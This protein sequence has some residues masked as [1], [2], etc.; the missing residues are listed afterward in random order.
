MAP[1]GKRVHTVSIHLDPAQYL[2]GWRPEARSLFVP[3]LSES[4]V[5][6]EAAVR[7]AI[8]GQTIR[9]TVYGKVAL[10]RRVGRPSLPPGAE[11]TLDRGSLPAAE[12]LAMASR[13]EKITYR[14]RSPRW[15]VEQ[16]LLVAWG[17]GWVKVQT[18]NVA[19]GGCA[20]RW[21]PPLP[22]VGEVLALRMPGSMFPPTARA[23]VC[24]TQAEGPLGRAIGLRVVVEGRGGRA[25]LE[26]VE[27][28]SQEG[29]PSA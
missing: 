4:R 6:D 21:A 18:I 24:W 7:V 8:V 26:L 11:L 16:T 19:E 28:A 5:G 23:I 9:A 15:P 29:K 1:A 22:S 17:G 13:G 14:E 3:A 20:L 2:A 25:W 27:Q 10:V 12:F